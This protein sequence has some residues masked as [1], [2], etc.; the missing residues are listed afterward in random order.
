MPDE[1]HDAINERR[2]GRI[3]VVD[4]EKDLVLV[5]VD[6]LKARGYHVEAA[7]SVKG[8]QE[9]IESF[10]AQVALLD[11]R[12]GRD[13]GVDLIAELELVR[14]GILCVMMTAYATVDT[15]I[16]ALHR[17]AY[18]YLRKPLDMRYL[19]AT[20]ER[21]F[22]KL[23]LESTK[24]AAE[25][26]LLESEAKFRNIVESI[27]MGMHMY[28]L[29]PDGKLVFTGAN[30]A[31]DEILGVNNDQFVGQTIEEAFPA[32]TETQVPGSYRQTAS[33]GNPW[34]T[35]Q[36]NYQENQIAGAF[37]VHA[38]QT[39]PGRMVAAFLD[40]TE[41]KR[42]EAEI[43][44]LQHLLQN[45][46]DSMP[47]ALITLDPAGRVLAC[48][49]AAEALTG[50]TEEQIQGQPL[51]RACPELER[52]HE[53]FEQVLRERQVAHRHKEQLE[54]EAGPLYR[55]VSV[56]PLAANDI[57]GAVL[58]IDD[59]TQ[60]VQLEEMMLQSARMA[61]VGMLAA[62]VA[63][64]INNP[65]GAMMQSAQMLQIAFDTQQ[66]HTRERLQACGVDPDGLAR[67]LQERELVEYLDGIR[68]TGSRAAK[69]VS[70]LLSFSRKS[71]SKIAP[72]DLNALVE[73]TLDLAAT[74][75]NLKKKYDFRNMEVVRELALDLPNVLC[76]GQQIQ[77]VILNLVRNAAQ[78]MANGEWRMAN[79]EYRPRLTLRT[80]L[81]QDT[82]SP[83][84]NPKSQIRLEVEDNGPGI[85]K[86]K[87]AR[88]F[89]PF[90]TTKEVGEGTGLGLW[91]CW[92]IVVER[93]KGRIWVEPI[94]EGGSRFVVEL[95]IASELASQPQSTNAP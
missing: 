57:E 73:R 94:V 66:P 51:W 93:H 78:A 44:R 56:F 6:T 60:R 25:E 75:Y 8:A 39:L 2:E 20:L 4:D 89:D 40:I 79:E 95:P 27:P 48:N 63:H 87:Q 21:C 33:E 16:N 38:F 92:S 62:G 26:A 83:I 69:I 52:Y 7:Y 55:D 47:S 46:T 42:D 17:G 76:D 54:S 84:P 81:T 67:Y 86:A 14:P 19:L 43:M 36:I 29:E 34:Q 53:L 9:K 35:E 77:Q 31:A 68:D 11:I 18:D 23:R 71:S 15:A 58:R 88:L 70:D 90:F 65:L 41:R 22:E 85:P 50:Q 28:Q 72:H 32:L 12:L 80:S 1:N 82:Q 5:L 24:A 10:D 49:P 13:S 30:P 45:I 37:Q 74:D 59:A 61:S 91:L 3:L 64:E